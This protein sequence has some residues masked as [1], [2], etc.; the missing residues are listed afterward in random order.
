M[1]HCDRRERMFA[2]AIRAVREAGEIAKKGVRARSVR[3]KGAKDPVTDIDIAVE[4]YLREA[5]DGIAPGVPVLG[6]E[7][8]TQ[9]AA[10]CPFWILDPIDGT[11][12]FTHGLEHWAISLAYYDGAMRFGIVYAPAEERLYTAYAGKGAQIE[13]HGE[14]KPL[15]VSGTDR[16]DRALAGA[17]IHAVPGFSERDVSERLE[18]ITR[19]TEGF[20][21]FGSAALDLCAVAEGALDLYDGRHLRLWDVAAGALIVRE[22]GGAC[23]LLDGEGRIGKEVLEAPRENH[24]IVASNAALREEA[25]RCFAPPRSLSATGGF[26]LSRPDDLGAILETIE[27]GRA[28]IASLGIDQ[29]QKGAPNRETILGHIRKNRGYQSEDALV[30]GAL[31]EDD[32]DYRS[33]LGADAHYLVLHTLAVRRDARGSG[34]VD[35][36]LDEMLR[37]A[38]MANLPLYADTHPGNLPMRSVL[39]RHGAQEVGEVWI[40]GTEYRIAYRFAD[41]LRQDRQ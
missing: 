8:E 26:R 25:L 36:F 32:P 41:D 40:G 20:R 22:S 14:R 15:A 16:L 33:L 30:F 31:V 7:A 34:L 1:E 24:C 19:D 11:M 27:S 13:A 2:S 5:L 12:N 29:W 21:V 17:T 6:E 10:E 3:Y 28:A 39:L 37:R 4:A 23:N 18:R 35:R 38:K 9:L